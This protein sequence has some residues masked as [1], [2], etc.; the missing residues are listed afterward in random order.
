MSESPTQ[1][2]PSS[3][4]RWHRWGALSTTG[5]LLFLVMIVVHWRRL[6][7]SHEL[8]YMLGSRRLADPEL[9]VHDLTWANLPPTS[10]LFDYLLAL[11][12]EWLS[13]WVLVNIGRF[14]TWGLT[15]WA[16][17]LLVR[18]LRLPWW[19]LLLG[20][21]L[22]MLYGQTLA[23]CGSPIEGFQVKSFSYP[24]IYFALYFA[25]RG[26]AIRAGLAV[27]LA[28][29]FHIIVGGWA[30]LGLFLSMAL[31]RRSFTG[32]QLLAFLLATVPF[33]LP[34]VLAVA[35]FHLN[36]PAG[37][38]TTRMD[39]I[40]VLFAMP[41]CCDPWHFMTP[42]RWDQA[43]MVFALTPLLV[44]YWPVR[45]AVRILNGFLLI[46][47]VLFFIGLVA[48]S[49]EM[50][51]F[52]KL[53]PFQLAKSLPLLFFFVFCL[54]YLQTTRPQQRLATLAWVLALTGLV[55][56]FDGKN[57]TQRLWRWPERFGEEVQAFMAPNP[58]KS[59][60]ERLYEWI[61]EHTPR[62]S[63]FITPL[64]GEFWAYAERAQVVSFSHPPL[65]H[66]ILE[67]EER[68]IALNRSQP[69]SK[70]G[71]RIREA[72]GEN[73]NALDIEQLL[74]IRERYGA[75]HYM[76]TQPRQ[77]LDE[78]VLFQTRQHYIYDVGALQRRL[79][80]RTE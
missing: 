68:L 76:T 9:L 64:L 72:F 15:A 17:T 13:E 27:G 25:I 29:A 16:L 32:R 74:Q 5:C 57:M 73:E 33:V 79:S 20:Y 3:D 39:A 48:R 6:L 66:R 28:T 50:F 42:A 70:R 53:Y 1:I 43:I 59:S 8:I 12:R 23:Y 67:W 65:N 54:A 58:R 77:D 18:V 56:Q 24:L 55:F 14:L 49:Y 36:A 30:C 52:L 45:R 44:H 2:A 47:I 40:Y 61:R 38:D 34:V 78:Y 31:N 37:A 19:S 69:F 51:W 7:E 80:Q 26:Q 46:L 22:W 41:H 11:P 10:L 35:L 21:M 75:T 60:K 71:F 62:D 63:V 4:G